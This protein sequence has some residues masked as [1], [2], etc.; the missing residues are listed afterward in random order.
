MLVLLLHGRKAAEG[1]HHVV[2]V[3]AQ[4]WI[5]RDLIVV[6]FLSA[7]SVSMTRFILLVCTMLSLL[8]CRR[9]VVE[10]QVA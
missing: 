1:A 7:R 3:I 2:E 9:L 4:G 5:V 6:L 10:W 8:L